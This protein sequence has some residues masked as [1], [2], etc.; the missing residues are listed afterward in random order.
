MELRSPSC[1]CVRLFSILHLAN[2]LECRIK[3]FRVKKKGLQLYERKSSLPCFSLFAGI[4][5]TCWCNEIIIIESKTNEIVL[6]DTKSRA[7]R[8]VTSI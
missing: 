1:D 2:Y 6:K 7:V 8:V 4:R 3:I 5:A